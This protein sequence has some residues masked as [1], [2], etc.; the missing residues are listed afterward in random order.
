MSRC[1]P[2]ARCAPLV[3]LGLIAGSL[4]PDLPA[5]TAC[6]KDGRVIDGKPMSREADALRVKFNAGDILIPNSM[7]LDVLLDADATDAA[8][9]DSMKKRLAERKAYIEELKLLSEWRNRKKESKAHF[10]FEYT[11]P[12]HIYAGFRDRMEAYFTEFQKKWQ[13]TQPK[14]GRL[15]VCFYG[16]EEAFH[17]VSSAERGV[18][19]YFRFVRP[20]ELDIYYDRLDPELTEDVMFHEANHYLQKL[21]NVD[22]K[23]PHFPGESLAEYYGASAWDD[24][25]KKLTVGLVQEG[26]LAEVMTDVQGGK[27]MSLEEM[28]TTD[29]KYEHYT[30][31][32]SLVHFL[33]NRDKY[34]PRFLKFVKTLA[35][36]KDVKRETQNFGADRLSFVDGAEILRVFMKSL[37]LKDKAALKALEKEWYDYITKELKADSTRGYEQAGLQVLGTYPPRPIRARMLLEKAVAGGSKNSHVVASLAEMVMSGSGSDEKPDADRA[38]DLMKKAIELDPL[39]ADNYAT[40]GDMLTAKGKKDEGKKLLELARELDPDDPYLDIRLRRGH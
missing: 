36:G 29:G 27:M 4:A 34:Q 11:V 8:K 17:Q 40:L 28:I 6:L 38:I 12:P 39:V 30:W 23:M 2:A 16:D 7:V 10:D 26:R 14:D 13:V 15:L 20:M 3:A 1:N 9:S 22:F 32:W 33:M 35:N 18:L 31:G 21:L 5:D 25:A 19:G 24:K 37:E